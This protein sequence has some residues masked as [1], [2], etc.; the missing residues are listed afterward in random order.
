M[1]GGKKDKKI[2]LKESE[3]HTKEGNLEKDYEKVPSQIE[4][5]FNG[6]NKSLFNFLTDREQET[7]W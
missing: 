7:E 6:L 5:L 4:G 3:F 2:K 1:R